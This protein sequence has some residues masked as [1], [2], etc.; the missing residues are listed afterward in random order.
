MQGG[1]GAATVLPEQTEAK[2]PAT[3]SHHRRGQRPLSPQQ[4]PRGVL[5][6]G[7]PRNTRPRPTVVAPQPPRASRRARAHGPAAAGPSPRSPGPPRGDSP[8]T[9][10]S[11]GRRPL[12]SEDARRCPSRVVGR[13][14]GRS[15]RGPWGPAGR[16]PAP[17]PPRRPGN[18]R[19]AARVSHSSARPPPPLPAAGGDTPPNRGTLRRRGGGGRGGGSDLG[20][21]APRRGA[22]LPSPG[23]GAAGAGVEAGAIGRGAAARAAEAGGPAGHQPPRPPPAIPRAR[24][25][26][27]AP[28]LL[29]A[30]EG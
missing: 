26:A 11:V 2:R 12:L 7:P 19:P 10:R 29:T 9:P 25:P 4:R 30:G 16:Q 22:A 17:S 27:R 6:R 1:T 5:G 15:R 21:V 20:G 13:G 23:S 28:P 24:P 3:P 14:V 18:G 8:R